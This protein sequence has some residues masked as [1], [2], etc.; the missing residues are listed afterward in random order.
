MK[1]KLLRKYFLENSKFLFIIEKKNKQNN[2]ILY[3]ILLAGKFNK[4]CI[5]HITAFQIFK[6]EMHYK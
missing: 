5:Q 4:F 6:M 1:E 2:Q 3:N